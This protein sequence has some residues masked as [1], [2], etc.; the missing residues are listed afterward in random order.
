MDEYSSLSKNIHEKDKCDSHLL[1]LNFKSQ[2]SKSATT[3]VVIL[4]IVPYIIS[5]ELVPLESVFNQ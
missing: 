4:K 3:L 1:F 5:I 2:V